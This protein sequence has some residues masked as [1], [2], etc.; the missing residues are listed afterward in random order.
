M[1]GPWNAAWIAT[2]VIEWT[3]LAKGGRDGAD[4][5]ASRQDGRKVLRCHVRQVR[6]SVRADC[7]SWPCSGRTIARP[8]PWI[9]PAPARGSPPAPLRRAGERPLPRNSGDTILTTQRGIMAT[10]PAALLRSWGRPS[11]VHPMGRKRSALPPDPHR[12]GRA[13]APRRTLPRTVRF[14]LLCR[15]FYAPHSIS[16]A[17]P[18]SAWASIAEER[19]L[20][21][22]PPLG[23]A[24]RDTG[25]PYPADS[26]HDGSGLR[27]AGSRNQCGVPGISQRPAFARRP[28]RLMA[29]ALTR[30]A[31]G[32]M[33]CSLTCLRVARR[34][35]T[36]PSPIRCS[37]GRGRETGLSRLIF[38]SLKTR[39]IP[40]DPPLRWW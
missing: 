7:G 29:E 2:V 21:A 18:L 16:A 12:E 35:A 22:V 20:P 31:S 8:S 5:Q 32:P 14:C 39:G 38:P 6:S 34:Q 11:R 28:T 10:P 25:R 36:F 37:H 9:P 33:N 17:P 23:D 40:L 24:A 1:V 4:E 26:H 27:P 13:A 19:R 3:A 30:P 15:L